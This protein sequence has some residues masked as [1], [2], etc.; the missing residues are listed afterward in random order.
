VSRVIIW[1]DLAIYLAVYTYCLREHRSGWQYL[2]GM[3][4]GAVGFV[5]WLIARI[6]LGDSFSPR[7]VARK[8]V[9]T[10]LYSRFRHPVYLFSTI[11]IAG[12]CFA[13]HWYVFGAIY[14]IFLS[15]VQW[16][17]ARAES[18]VLLAAF[19][20]QYREYRARTWF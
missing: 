16:V 14:V 13:M 8:L 10:G 20:E 15:L 2:T 17:R 7:A 4:I 19:G 3:V 9:T 6:Q 5:L 1:F 18:R 11:G 12:I